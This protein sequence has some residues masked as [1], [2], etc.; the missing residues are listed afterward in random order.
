MSKKL[1]LSLVVGFSMVACSNSDFTSPKLQGELVI[2]NKTEETNAINT[3]ITKD[4]KE[5]SDDIL[6]KPAPSV[7]QVN[8]D[9][10]EEK[11]F[12]LPLPTG[13]QW[14]KGLFDS[15]KLVYLPNG[16]IQCQD[17]TIIS[18][19]LEI[20]GSCVGF[21]VIADNADKVEDGKT[22]DE[23][24]PTGNIKCK[25]G[26]FISVAELGSKSEKCLGFK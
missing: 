10:S 17:G 21:P 11:D 4:V 7:V 23:V 12:G 22:L 8:I 26:T 15:K 2:K 18:S 16:K 9:K 14:L 19:H 5:K 13:N 20:T 3:N 1:V 6:V 25:D 24:L